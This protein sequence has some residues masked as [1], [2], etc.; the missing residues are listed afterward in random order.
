MKLETG[1]KNLA[2]WQHETRPSRDESNQSHKTLGNDSLFPLKN[3]K[4]MK[5]HKTQ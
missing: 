5:E 1:L 3:L 2:R 4:K